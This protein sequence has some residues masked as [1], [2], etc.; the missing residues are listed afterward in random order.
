MKAHHHICL[1]RAARADIKL[2]LT[3]LDNF[4]GRAFFLS[5][6]WETFAT[7]QLYTDAA[8][9]RVM[10]RFLVLIGFMAR[11]L[12]RGVPLVSLVSHSLQLP[13][14]YIYGGIL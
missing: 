6:H 7:L 10:A 5:D 9:R 13:L 4:N 2:W 14:P 8:G 3:F 11:G 1:T 12:D